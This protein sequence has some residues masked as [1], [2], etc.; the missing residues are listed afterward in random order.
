MK[1]AQRATISKSDASVQFDEPETALAFS[2]EIWG[3]TNVR[4]TQGTGDNE[5]F[6]PEEYISLA[7]HVLG[8]IDLDPATHQGAQNVV[9]AS[10]Y[11]TK[12]EDGLS[13]QWHGRVWLNPPYAQPWIQLFVMKLLTERQHGNVS[14]AIM[15]THNYTDTTWFQAA[16]AIT[17]ALCFTRGRVKFYE[18][19]GNIAAPTQGQA[20]FYFGLDP[21]RFAQTFSQIGSVSLWNPYVEQQILAPRPIG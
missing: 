5:W 2:R 7:R 11:F 18:P 14:A 1:A 17:D 3:H 19:N 16:L 13:Q 12:T 6:T 21:K 9:K 4:G 15:L 10:K 8:E 20:F